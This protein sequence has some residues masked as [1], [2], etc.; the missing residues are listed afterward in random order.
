MWEQLGDY[1][2]A[3]INNGTAI[4]KFNLLDY[5]INAAVD[6]SNQWHV[7]K[8]KSQGKKKERRDEQ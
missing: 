1:I 4:S 7:V 6:D 8:S 5:D 2:S 3:N